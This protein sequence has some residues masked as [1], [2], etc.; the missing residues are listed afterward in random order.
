LFYHRG[1]EDAEN[2]MLCCSSV[3]S[4]SLW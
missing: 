4:V 2:S 3:S 1:T